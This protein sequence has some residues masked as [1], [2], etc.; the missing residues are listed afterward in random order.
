MH[1]W[2]EEGFRRAASRRVRHQSA[3][4]GVRGVRALR[5]LLEVRSPLGLGGGGGS[6]A[7]LGHGLQT[8]KLRVHLGGML[9]LRRADECARTTS[10]KLG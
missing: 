5:H 2:H 6:L 9:H 3:C 7:R 1:A 8:R 10:D 4:R